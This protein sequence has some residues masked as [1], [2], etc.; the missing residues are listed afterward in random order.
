MSKRKLHSNP[1]SGFFRAS[2]SNA[3]R[4]WGC[5]ALRASVRI[6]LLAT[7]AFANTSCLYHFTGGGLPDHIKTIFI[8]PLE[9][10][11]QQFDIDQQILRLLNE[12]LP[13]SLGIRPG[14]EANANAIVRG[15]ITSYADI[16]TNYK[17]GAPG[18]IEVL[19]HNVTI[20]MTIRIV[21]VEKNEILYESSGLSGRG[22][23]RPDTQS[24]VVARTRAIEM[25]IQ[26]IIDGAQ[27]QW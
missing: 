18:S 25:L 8:A 9:N 20:S 22:E 13:R 3:L 14:T 4:A 27:S 15:T 5:N 21:D 16:A 24:D 10:Q 7:I 17:S 11:T 6:A 2:A 19:Q 1:M 12:K 23:Y 26:Q